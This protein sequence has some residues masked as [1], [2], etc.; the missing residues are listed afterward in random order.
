MIELE[1]FVLIKADKLQVLANGSVCLLLPSGSL[2]FFY[3]TFFL[4]FLFLISWF[5]SNCFLLNEVVWW[6]RV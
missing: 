1:H 6:T 4:K 2:L 3:F 5:S